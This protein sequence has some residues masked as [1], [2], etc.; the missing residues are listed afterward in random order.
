VATIKSLGHACYSLSADGHS[1]VFDPWL[2]GNPE[3]VCTPGELHVDAVL[4]SHGHKDHLGDSIAIATRLGIPVIGVYELCMY[5]ARHGC[6]IAPM[7]LGGHRDF[8][9]GRV[10]LTVAT[11]GSAVIHDD[12]IECLGPASGFL[13]TMGGITLYFAGDTGLF[14]DMRLI[15][16]SV[17]VDAA[18]LPIGD[19]F[20]MGPHDALLAVEMIRPAVVIPTHYSAFDAINQDAKAFAAEVAKLG[21]ECR[22]LG[23]GDEANIT[24][25]S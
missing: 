20:T 18:I 14:G 7:H 25:D 23:P 24:P 3:A 1:V 22:V 12:R 17:K 15:G 5:C 11:H 8:D 21:I 9:F 19:C 4:A 2:E 6:E 10:K 16:D 13:V